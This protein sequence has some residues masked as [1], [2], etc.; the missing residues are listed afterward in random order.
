MEVILTQEVRPLGL[1]G[2]K[3]SVKD[4]YAR[5]FLM[6][7]GLAVPADRGADSASRARLNANLRSAELAKEKAVEIAAKLE[8]TTCRFSLSSG[9][10]GKL[11]GAVTA[12]D[13]AR[14]L[15]NQG[16]SIEKHQIQLDGPLSQLGE[17]PV[18]VRLHPEVKA[19]VK[20]LLLKA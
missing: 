16:I 6:P 12:S 18:L 7:R 17:H 3:V 9:E 1:A 5:N 2:Q 19:T 11:H 13:I 4:G 14:E 10:Q 8:T 20:V 15:Q